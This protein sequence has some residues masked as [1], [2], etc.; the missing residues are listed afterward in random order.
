MASL[1]HLLG[2]NFSPVPTHFSPDKPF[3]PPQWKILWINARDNIRLHTS[4]Y[5]WSVSSRF[6][7]PL[8]KIDERGPVWNHCSQSYLNHFSPVVRVLATPQRH[9]ITSPDTL[10]LMTNISWYISCHFLMFSGILPR[11]ATSYSLFQCGPTT[12]QRVVCGPPQR[13]RWPADALRKN[14]Q[15]WNMLKCVWGLC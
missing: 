4:K 14:I 15:I 10:A 7:L 2:S 6:M 11:S 12:G 13:Y 5:Y 1:T 8:S 9:I 3:P